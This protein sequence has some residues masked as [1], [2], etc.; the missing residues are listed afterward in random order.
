MKYGVELK[1]LQ[2]EILD[3]LV[4]VSNIC[5]KNNIDYFIIG[6][7][8]L[9]AIRHKGFIPWDDDIDIGMTRENYDKFLEIAQNSLS[10]NLFL[11]TPYT[12]KHTPFYYTKVRKKGTLFV[13][14]YCRKLNIE[15]GV[16]I[17]IFPYDNIPDDEIVYKK[18]L[19]KVKFF[20]QLFIAKEICGSSIEQNSIIGKLKVG[21]RTFAHIVLKIIPKK[22]ILRKLEKECRKYNYCNTNRIGFIEQ[23]VLNMKSEYI[24]ELEYFRFEDKVF[25]G[26]KG[27]KEYLV[28]QFGD[29][30]ILPPIDKRVGHKPY[31]LK[32]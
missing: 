12:E 13:E 8:A 30:K 18:Q 28:D 32:I 20:T 5:E 23:T 17:D 9:G 15:H 19:K 2:N 22:Y 6:G 16:F 10:S 14:K 11:Q 29:Y 3:I 21:I 31:K 24:K 7:T 25:K 27:I 26:P 1:K 4:E